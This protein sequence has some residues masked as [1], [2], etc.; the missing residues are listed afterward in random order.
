MTMDCYQGQHR[1]SIQIP[2]LAESSEAAVSAVQSGLVAALSVLPS[3]H[4]IFVALL[5]HRYEKAWSL[6]DVCP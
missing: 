5:R 1:A 3:I 2:S 4:L 6:S